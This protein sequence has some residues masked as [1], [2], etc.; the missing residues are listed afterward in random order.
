VIRIDRELVVG[1]PTDAVF[2]YLI[3]FRHLTEW[4]PGVQIAEQTT[5][6]PLAVGSRFR[7]VMN[8]P[9]GPLEAEGEVTELQRPS[10]LAVRSLSGPAD[11]EGSIDLETRGQQTALRI[12]ASLQPKGM[13]RFAE[14]VIRGVVERELPSALEKLREHLESKV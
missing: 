6:G 10:R 14:S 1:R 5:P 11:L 2:D 4:Q 3:D 9:A 7:L 8:G 13:L 12:A